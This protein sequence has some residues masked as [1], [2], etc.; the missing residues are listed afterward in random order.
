MIAFSDLARRITEHYP[1][2]SPKLQQAA[3]HVLR[4]PDDVALMSMRRLAAE[5][6]VHPSTMIRL[7]HAFG[8]PGYGDFREPFQQRLRSRPEGYLARA[9]TLQARGAEDEAPRLLDEVLHSHLGNLRETFE[10]AGPKPYLEFVEDLVAAR[11]LFVV[12]QRSCFPVAFFF[13]H[14][15]RMFRSN[16]IL[17]QGPGGTFADE[18]RTLRS[19]D[20]TFAISVQPYSHE[21]VRAV[22]YT[23]RQGGKALVLTDS[24]VSP[25][26]RY[27][28]RVL[29]AAVETPSFFHSMTPAMAA[30]EALITLMVARG[31]A[32]A[33]ESIEESEAQL[34]EFKAYWHQDGDRPRSARKKGRKGGP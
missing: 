30:A 28:D 11:R 31:G 32:P 29:I 24:P 17:L 16:G 27:A 13:S 18:L 2:L 9:R 1:V 8:L 20:A 34:E 4:R 33:L 5:A 19:G 25:L 14:V 15:Y 7:A 3:Q 21:T 6:G 10:S 23:K 22:E 26:A 12:G